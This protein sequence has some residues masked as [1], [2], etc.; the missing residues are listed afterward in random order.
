MV[1]LFEGVDVGMGWFGVGWK[2]GLL[3]V[4]GLVVRTKDVLVFGVKM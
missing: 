4:C 2:G 3:S 1:E